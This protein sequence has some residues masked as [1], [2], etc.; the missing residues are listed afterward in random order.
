MK[1]SNANIINYQLKFKSSVEAMIVTALFIA[2]TYVFI[3]FLPI[4][5]PG[6]GSG[7][8][9][10]LGNVPMLVGAILFGKKVG[11]LSGGIGMALFDLLSPYAIWAPYTLVIVAIMGYVVGAIAEKHNEIKWYIVSVFLALVIKVVGYYFAE[12]ILFNWN[13]I[14]PL[15]SIIG[16]V[17]QVAVAGIFVIPFIKYL[18]K[19]L[20][21]T[22]LFG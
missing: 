20:K 4:Q 3:A 19:I 10:H 8:L 9:V 6:L 15:L 12:V 16:N 21:K 18:R 14:T 17:S 5:L 11:A 7:G 13:F 22:N 1:K 2:L